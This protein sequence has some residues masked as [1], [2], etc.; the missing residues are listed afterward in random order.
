MCLTLNFEDTEGNEKNIFFTL[1]L[2]A[3]LHT[4]FCLKK[5]KKDKTYGIK[6]MYYGEKTEKGARNM[7]SGHFN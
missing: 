6:D 1:L 4:S 7:W 5:K 3:L 2:V